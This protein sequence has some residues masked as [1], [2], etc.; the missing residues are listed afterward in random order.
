MDLYSVYERIFSDGK[1]DAGPWAPGQ[2]AREL[3]QQVPEIKYATGF[4][5]YDGES[6]FSLDDK[7]INLK[8]IAADSDFLRCSIT[9]C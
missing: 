9:P 4:W 8:G 3:K 2:L 7:K 1:I 5:R 6:L